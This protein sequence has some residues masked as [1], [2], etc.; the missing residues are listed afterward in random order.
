[1]SFTIS[2]RFS[3]SCLVSS[4][5]ITRLVAFRVLIGGP[6]QV[7]SHEKKSRH[8]CSQNNLQSDLQFF[9]WRAH[10]ACLAGWR[11]FFF[12]LR[13][14]PLAKN[15]AAQR[16]LVKVTPHSGLHVLYSFGNVMT[17]VTLVWIHRPLDIMC[18]ST[19]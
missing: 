14:A 13:F 6:A 5:S 9:F 2:G 11:R 16:T 8:F 4:I 10:L 3:L 1:M 15:R 17:R 7:Q 18:T 12:F 19:K